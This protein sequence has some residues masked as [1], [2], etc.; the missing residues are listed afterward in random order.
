MKI[1]SFSG[2]VK[3]KGYEMIFCQKNSQ[4]YFESKKT[5]KKC[6]LKIQ[7]STDCSKLCMVEIAQGISNLM[8]QY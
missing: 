8:V 6:Y 5:R 3:D 1:I 7:E 4:K 2:I